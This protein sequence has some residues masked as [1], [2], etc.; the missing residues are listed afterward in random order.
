MPKML[1]IVKII[2]SFLKC[3]TVDFFYPLY[4]NLQIVFWNFLDISK[5]TYG[6]EAVSE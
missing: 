4:L 6:D 1:K 3:V 2:K 5:N